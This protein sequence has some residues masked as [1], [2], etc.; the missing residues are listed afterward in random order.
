MKNILITGITG[1]DGL[2]L[3]KLLIE[4]EEKYNIYGTTRKNNPLFFNRLKTITKEE[5]KDIVLNEVNL[6]SVEELSK[7]VIDIE[8]DYVVNLSGPSSVYDS[9]TNKNHSFYIEEIF[10]NL[11]KSVEKLK[12]F[13]N[14]FQASSSE[15]FGNNGKIYQNEKGPFYPISPYAISKYKIH[16]SIENFTNKM[17]G[18]IVAGIMFNHES[19]FRDNNFLFKK[20][21]M[22]AKNHKNE[23][24]KL[25]LGSL[26]Y[27]RDWSFAE[28]ICEGIYQ[29]LINDKSGSY[30]L[31]SG[32][33]TSIRYVLEKFFLYTD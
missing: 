14:F 7:F 26:D 13:P 29:L 2:Y 24:E 9:I 8:P 1:Q 6:L 19:K 16:N 15:M 33:G 23:T 30:V 11:L 3:T 31:G 5:T 28:D 10:Q 27:I 17:Q 21:A 18:N 12:K 20:I 22:Y 4:S 25:R 32:E